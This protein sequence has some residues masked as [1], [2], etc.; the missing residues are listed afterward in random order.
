VLI[1]IQSTVAELTFKMPQT[2]VKARIREELI[3]K[4]DNAMI[5]P[6]GSQPEHGLTQGS[7]I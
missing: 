2:E 6:L 1:A 5:K 7:N 3:P 4:V